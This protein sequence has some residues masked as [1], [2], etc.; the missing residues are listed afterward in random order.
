MIRGSLFPLYSR[1][2]SL[3]IVPI[4]RRTTL[5]QR[6]LSKPFYIYYLCCI[7]T[8]LRKIFY[9]RKQI[10]N[11]VIAIRKKSRLIRVLKEDDFLYLSNPVSTNVN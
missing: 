2:N 6:T 4:L 7:F 1:E 9:S 11:D 5:Q 10:T 3:L 8:L